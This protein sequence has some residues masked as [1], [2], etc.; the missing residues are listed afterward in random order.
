M[1]L[2]RTKNKY[3]VLEWYQNVFVLCNFFVAAEPQKVR[4][5]GA[6]SD[7]QEQLPQRKIAT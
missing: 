5:C 6:K 3:V 2:C 4:F 7:L 1:Q